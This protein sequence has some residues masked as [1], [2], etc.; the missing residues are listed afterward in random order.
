MDGIDNSVELIRGKPSLLV[1]TVLL[2]SPTVPRWVFTNP[3]VARGMD[4]L[5]KTKW[6]ERQERRRND[7]ERLGPPSRSAAPYVGAD[8]TVTDSPAWRRADCER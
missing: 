7:D 3:Q 4:A 6:Y 5:K 2:A 8:G 1:A